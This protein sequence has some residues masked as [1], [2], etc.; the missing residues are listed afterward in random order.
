MNESFSTP[1]PLP[2]VPLSPRG[3]GELFSGFSAQYAPPEDN[4]TFFRII[5]ALLKRPGSIAFSIMNGQA[6][7]VSVSLFVAIMACLVAYGALMATFSGGPQLWIVP[8]K[9]WLGYLFSAVL[10]LPS[11]YI[12]VCLS[13]GRLSLAQL[14]ALL[15]QSLALSAL[16][17]VGFAPIVWIF[18]QS[19]SGAGFM[20][21]LHFAFWIISIYFAL[22]LL[23]VSLEFINRESLQA[24]HVWSLI[25]IVV[26]FQMCTFLRPLVGE[27][28][29]LQLQGKQF[30]LTH[31]M[32]TLDGK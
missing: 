5:D 21:F 31:W 9:V 2:P 16:L 10:C 4:F 20:G 27:F 28:K 30:F 18:S 1:P 14:S 12:F 3:K 13:G 19:T 25:F 11:L 32:N 15:L 6:A 24:L 7:R 8:L 17:L 26:V 29:G 22:R 23:T